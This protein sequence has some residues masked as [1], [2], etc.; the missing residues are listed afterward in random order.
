MDKLFE[1]FGKS[2]LKPMKCY[3]KYTLETSSCRPKGSSYMKISQLQNSSNALI[4]ESLFLH[5]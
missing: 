1:H 2:K 3:T 5:L 4:Y